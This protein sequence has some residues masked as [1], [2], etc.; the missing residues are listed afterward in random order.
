MVLVKSCPQSYLLFKETH[1]SQVPKPTG[2]HMKLY[3][4][5]RS[6]AAF[7]VRIALNLKNIPYQAENINLLENQQN[8]DPYIAI[9][10]QGLVPTLE[11]D[12]GQKITQS[13]AILEYLEEQ[14]PEP[15][16]YPANSLLK[17]KARSLSNMI[18][19]DI[20]PLNN[21]RVLKYLQNEFQI[22]EE[23]KIAWYHYWI[24]RSFVAIESQLNATPYSMG[25]EVSMVDVYLVPQVF[26]CLRFDLDMSP[27]Q[28]ILSVY[29]ACN[30]L[31]AF[32]K[33]SPQNQ[34]SEP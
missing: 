17:A 5:S 30:E 11:L 7:R 28:G 9:N 33:A 4:Y 10:P 23:T 22:S 34:T 32:Q 20:H 19:C 2:I 18:A 29:N 3:D 14:Y 6:T 13:T 27:F 12:N 1:I 24:N 21:L 25:S 16:L 8:S 26:N 31:G 15:N